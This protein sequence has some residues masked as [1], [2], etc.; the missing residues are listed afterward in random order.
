MPDEFEAEVDLMQM[1]MY[2]VPTAGGKL[3]L[4]FKRR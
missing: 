3:G 1:Q 4:P 2:W